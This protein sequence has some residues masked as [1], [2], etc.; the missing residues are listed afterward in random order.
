MKRSTLKRGYRDTGPSAEVVQLVIERDGCCV[1]CGSAAQGQRGVDWS[2]Q[3]RKKRSAGI[4]NSLSNLILLCG[5]GTTGCH[6][7]VEAHPIEA[8][9]AGGWSVSRYSNPSTTPVLVR[10]EFGERWVYLTEAG[11]YADSPVVS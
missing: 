5:S 6:G 10:S 2:I 7:W 3:H 9:H 8:E 4:D 1:R 11:E